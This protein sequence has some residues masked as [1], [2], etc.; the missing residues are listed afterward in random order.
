MEYS[1]S[2]AQ[3]D[4]LDSFG[5]DQIVEHHRTYALTGKNRYELTQLLGSS[6]SLETA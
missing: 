1:C 3:S 4:L 5:N 6:D 2:P